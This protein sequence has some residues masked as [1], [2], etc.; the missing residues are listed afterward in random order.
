MAE[1]AALRMLRELKVFDKIP[2]EGSISYRDL[3]ASVGAEEALLS[4]YA[5]ELT[6]PR[7]DL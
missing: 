2:Q 3:A 1:L 5:P 6:F 4:T 7:T